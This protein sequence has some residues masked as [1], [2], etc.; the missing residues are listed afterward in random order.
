MKVK[1]LANISHDGKTYAPG[2][3]FE[4]P[5]GAAEQLL[6]INKVETVAGAS[7]PPAPPPR[8]LREGDTKRGG[9][10]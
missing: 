3:V 9:K 2:D 8:R 6:A 4:C 1:A 5:K 10:P 7:P